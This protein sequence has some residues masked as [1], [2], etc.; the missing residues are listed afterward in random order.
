VADLQAFIAIDKNNNHTKELAEH[1]IQTIKNDTYHPDMK[2]KA[3]DTSGKWPYLESHLE[4]I[5]KIG[6]AD[7][8]SITYNNKNLESLIKNNELKYLTLQHRDSFMTK[9]QAY[10]KIIGQMHR[11]DKTT[12]DRRNKI[13]ATL[14]FMMIANKNGY[15]TK[16]IAKCALQV[17]CKTDNKIWYDIS[18]LLK[19]I[20]RIWK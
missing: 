15:K 1:I 2:L 5:S 14:E 7:S 8:I 16:T 13:I 19:E 20:N 11:I 4:I 9:K 10:A 17:F 12:D 3:E 6:K 18:F